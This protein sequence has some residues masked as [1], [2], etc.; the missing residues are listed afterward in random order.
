MFTVQG[1]QAGINL[2]LGRYEQHQLTKGASFLLTVSFFLVFIQFLQHVSLCGCLVKVV[3]G[4]KYD[5]KCNKEEYFSN[6]IC[7][8]NYSRVQ[9]KDSSEEGQFN[10][11]Q[12]SI[13]LFRV[14]YS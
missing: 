10:C 7:K 3:N 11:K 6:Q 1:R 8:H 14:Q 4:A 9:Q 2:K 12:A 13:Y 5:R